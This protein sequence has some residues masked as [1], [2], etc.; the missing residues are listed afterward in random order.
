MRQE[1]IAPGDLRDFTY[2]S[3]IIE[4]LMKRGGSIRGV[5]TFR[6]FAGSVSG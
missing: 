1:L 5:V 4:E 3:R 2:R 6:E